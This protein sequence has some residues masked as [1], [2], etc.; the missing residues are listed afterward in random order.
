MPFTI[1]DGCINCAACVPV[2]PNN[3]IT[4]GKVVY[5]IDKDSCTE[6]VGFFSTPQ[7]VKVCPMDCCVLH[8]GMVLTEQ[9]LFERAKAIH[10][11]SNPQ[12]TLTANTSHFRKAAAGKWWARLLGLPGAAATAP[13]GQE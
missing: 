11:N 7:C 10:A 3:G 2:C 6:C 12:P 1:T 8:P 13:T 9:A 4:K 5:V